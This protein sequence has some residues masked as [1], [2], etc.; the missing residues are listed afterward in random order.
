MRKT[1]LFPCLALLVFFSPLLNPIV[2]MIGFQGLQYVPSEQEQQ[3]KKRASL[4]FNQVPG[5]RS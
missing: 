5:S 4:V 3:K 1:L 2:L